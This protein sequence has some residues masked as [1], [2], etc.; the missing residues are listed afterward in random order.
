ESSTQVDPRL[1]TLMNSN[2]ENKAGREVQLQILDYLW[3]ES[4]THSTAF[5]YHR[6]S[7]LAKVVEQ[8][9]KPEVSS[10]PTVRYD[11]SSVNVDPWLADQL[12]N[13]FTVIQRRKRLEDNIQILCGWSQ[14]VRFHPNLSRLDAR[15]YPWEQWKTL[16]N[17][18]DGLDLHTLL[19]E[20]QSNEL[21][22]PIWHGSPHAHSG[23]VTKSL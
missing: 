12:K 11:A 16:V 15:R 10:N 4:A 8:I 14:L 3:F 23:D 17:R 21:Y 18:S 22:K 9:C 2:A 5:T 13:R 1:T 20:I 19:L 6:L 7:S